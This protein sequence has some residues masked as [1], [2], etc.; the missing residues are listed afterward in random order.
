MS[1]HNFYEDYE[2]TDEDN[3][4]WT[5][6]DFSK[7]KRLSELP[8]SLQTKLRGLGR[9]KAEVTKERITIRLSPNVVEAFRATGSGWQTRMDAALNDWLKKHDPQ[10]IG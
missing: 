9:P 10:T 5:E 6:V 2:I 3:P 7:A 8:E 4:E 1:N